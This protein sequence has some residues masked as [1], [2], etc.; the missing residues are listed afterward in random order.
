[1]EKYGIIYLVVNNVNNKV[2][3]GQTVFT[4]KKRYK[5]NFVKETK[6]DY[7]K[8]AIKK[9]GIEN[10]IIT[11]EFDIG[12]SKEE[13]DELEKEYI[14]FYKANDKS[15]GY[16]YLS[17]GHNGKHNAESKAKIGMKQ[18]GELNHMYGKYGKDNP[19]YTRVSLK[20]D[21]CGIDIEVLKCNLKRSIHHY[22]SKEC[23]SEGQSRYMKKEITA[24]QKYS[25]QICGETFE[26]YPSQV[27][28]RKHLYCSRKC[29]NKGFQELFKGKDNPNFANGSKIEGSKNGRAKKVLCITTGE[30]FG[31]S[32]DAETKY[33]IARG[34][35]SACC[36]GKQKT[37]HDFEWKYID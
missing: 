36:R 19:K 26:K 8:R 16:N 32:R 14:K 35:V 24:K 12:Y 5:N 13:L 7:L 25:C 6:N 31:C 17:G 1:M 11:E 34:C 2:Y 4:F 33:S 22:C 10:F 18:I 28:D 30:V 21:I 37:S 20:C 27:K 29:Q 15:Y 3:V 9:Y 23:R